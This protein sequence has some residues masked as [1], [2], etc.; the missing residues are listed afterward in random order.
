MTTV[1]FQGQDL[2]VAV[3]LYNNMIAETQSRDR[4]R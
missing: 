2:I 3:L 1:V 4:N